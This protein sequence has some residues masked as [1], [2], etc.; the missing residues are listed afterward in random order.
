MSLNYNIK[1]IEDKY[2]WNKISKKQLE[3][4][5]KA[6]SEKSNGTPIFSITRIERKDGIY[7]MSTEL[8]LLIFLSMQIG[9]NKFTKSNIHKV[10]NR[11]NFI[12]LLNGDGFMITGSGK[13]KKSVPFTLEMITNYIGLETN[14]TNL[15]KT[16]FIKMQTKRFDF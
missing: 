3:K 6:K 11:I 7:Q 1:Q 15:T 2:C 10:Y 8:Y 9:I 14:V 5:E 13:N 12:D 16:Q 4:E